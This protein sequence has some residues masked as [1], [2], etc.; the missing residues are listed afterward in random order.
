MR[1]T[2]KMVQMLKTELFNVVCSYL[3]KN[4]NEMCSVTSV[5]CTVELEIHSFVSV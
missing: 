3:I 1:A 5:E 4:G 2:M